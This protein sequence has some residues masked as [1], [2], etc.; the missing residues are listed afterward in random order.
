MSFI[1]KALIATAAITATYKAID[2]L[3]SGWTRAGEA[4]SKATSEFENANSE[5]E[6]LKSQKNTQ[7]NQV[8]EIAAKYNIDS[9]ELQDAN[10]ELKD[11]D[12]MI[13]T[14]NSH[15]GISLV[16]RAELDSISSAN[17]QLEAQL[18]IQEQITEAKKQAM[19]LATEKAASTNKTYFEQMKEEYG[20]FEG[21]FKWIQGQGHVEIDEHG[22]RVFKEK[23]DSEKF[24]GD[25]KDS[26]TLGLF[27]KRLSELQEYKSE[28]KDLDEEISKSEKNGEKISK[29]TI[30]RRNELA[31]SIANSSQDLAGLVDA[32][33]SQMDILSQSD[34]SFALSWV[35]D[36][37]KAINDFNNID[38]SPDERA[39][40]DLNTYFDGSSGKNFI[41]DLLTD[42]AKSG[43]DLE[44][45]LS[46][47]GLNLSDI[48]SN[49]DSD[50]LTS[51]FKDIADA[52]KEA[53]DAV[54]NV[55]NNLTVNDIAS[56]FE[57]KNAGDDY[58]SLNDYLKKAKDLYDKGLVGTD[59]FKSVA[60]AI[61]YN[62]DSSAESFK[63]NYDK[64]QRYF[65]EDKDGN[66]TGEGIQNFL[67]DLQALNKGYA[68]WNDEAGKWD[69]NMD[70]TAQAA[71]DLN[72]SVQT[73]E[74]VLGRIKDY[75]GVGD[76]D[77]HSAIQDFETARQSLEGLRS[78]YDEMQDGDS[79][80]RV[81]KKLENWESQLGTWEEDLA[82][83][84]TDVVL[85]IK[86]EYDLASIQAQIDE[87]QELIDGGD[88]SVA[89]YSKVIAG[90][91]KYINTAEEGLGLN[92]EGVKIPVEYEATEKTI[93]SLKAQLKNVT[94]DEDKVEIQAEITNLQELQKQ[95]LDGFSTAHPEINAESSMEEINTAWESFIASAEGQEIVANITANSENAKE[96][97]A[98]ILGIEPEDISV[99]V[100]ANDEASE[101]INSVN[102]FEVTDKIVKLIGKDDASYVLNMW[103]SLS[104]NPKF[105]S[106]TAQDQATYVIQLWNSLTPEQKEAYMNGEI[107]VTDNATG[108]VMNVDNA[109]N[110]LP[111][112]PN[113]KITA[114][115]LTSGAVASANTSLNSISG[116]TVHT[117]IVTHKSETGGK[118]G[119]E[120][121]AHVDGTVKGL[122]PIP[123]LSRRAL[124]MGT[125]EDTSW[126][127]PQWKTKKNDVALTGEVGQELVVK[128]N[129]WWT[130]GDNG[131][132]FSTI[133][134]GAIVFNAKQ[135]KELFKNGFTNSRGVAHLNGTAYA[136][137]ASGSFSFGGGASK[138]NGKSSKKKNPASSNNSSPTPDNSSSDSAKDFKET[139]D[140]IEMAIDRIERQIKNVERIAGSAY[141]T[142]AKRNNAL[143]DQLSSIN[144]ELDIQQAGYDRYIQEADSVSLSEDYKDQV[145]NGTIDIST[146]TDESLAGNI[147]DF[148]QWY[149]KALDCRDA[150]E[151]LKE[152]VRDLYKE[153]FD[154]VVTLYDGMLGQIEHRQKIL[155]GF[156]DQ[157]ET[158]GYIVSTRYYD[159]LISNEQGKL[160]K[161]IKQRQDSIAAM[162][163]AIINGNIE[164]NSEQW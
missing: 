132:E 8:Q 3:Q 150:V 17:S 118:A 96:E 16:D 60:E 21:F 97:V 24:Y 84:D 42:A 32:I 41:K 71:K 98:E 28:L 106:L 70:N 34:S 1:S 29:D 19:I 58:V 23:S 64:L 100:T 43:S 124:A 144:E 102:L 55:N 52:A 61:S 51:Y 44:E 139:I 119:L 114:N 62:I 107:T 65:I 68:T 31:D 49:V 56:A 130:V 85:N 22:E 48:G 103:N 40:N 128:G 162:N 141:N 88:D 13:A 136:G 78:V 157:T 122:Y 151:E 2:Y 152:S 50:A 156:I 112:N 47:L 153:A 37:K 133:P 30:D 137:G 14:V 93:D 134:Q 59:D 116:K 6:S 89:N 82:T 35:E 39:L 138:Y 123:K 145:R 109:L 33:S 148:Q 12:Q 111:L 90:N 99:N 91:Q 159:A 163:D 149:E 75:D 158:Q 63:A 120:G 76:F 142:F 15:D 5:L 9:T 18:A 74:A 131:A 161:L 20:A 45:V 11:I 146:I 105:A 125:L 10:G 36:A 53:S 57:S 92:T 7:Q 127:K 46:G 81:G 77:F 104:A 164:V 160:E 113:A 27:K 67:T 154:N 38:L 110:S 115:D 72:V 129:R 86:L 79:K 26:T 155:E 147:K 87:A 143:K 126:L 101:T 69:I 83:L 73:M 117:Y 25:D 140:Y 4:A 94:S 80:K 95:L 135:T 108:T 121:T 66:L 54:D